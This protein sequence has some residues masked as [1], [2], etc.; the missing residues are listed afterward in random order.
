MSAGADA[1]QPHRNHMRSICRVKGSLVPSEA[2]LDMVDIG[3]CDSLWGK[4]LSAE[5]LARHHSK[6]ALRRAI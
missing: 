2:S 3:A 1:A 6:Y 5:A 4:R